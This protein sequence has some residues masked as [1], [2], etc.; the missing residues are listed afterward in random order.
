MLYMHISRSDLSSAAFKPK[1]LEGKTKNIAIRE[2]LNIPKQNS[3][4]EVY[5]KSN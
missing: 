1:Y 5:K 2:S 3:C 4:N